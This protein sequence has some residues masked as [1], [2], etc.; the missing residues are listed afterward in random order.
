M[1]EYETLRGE[2]V[3]PVYNYTGSLT[4]QHGRY[5]DGN[6]WSDYIR[7]INESGLYLH[8]LTD[9]S[10]HVLRNVSRSSIEF[11]G[12]FYVAS[13]GFTIGESFWS[14]QNTLIMDSK[15]D[16]SVVVGSGTR[17]ECIDMLSTAVTSNGDYDRGMVY[18]TEML[19]VAAAKSFRG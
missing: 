4:S 3:F 9:P 1:F 5:Y 6:F 17:S 12:K 11:T 10:H 2:V 15:R 14:N 8:Y 16:G 13:K 18:N 19:P 7:Q